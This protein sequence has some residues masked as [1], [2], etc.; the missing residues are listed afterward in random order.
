[1]GIKIITDS[2]SDLP[3]EIL[4]EYDI[5]VV[6]LEIRFDDKIFLDGIELMKNEFYNMMKKH[7]KL[8]KTAS[9]S[10][11]KFISEFD[12]TEDDILIITISSG[13]SST[14]N[15]A[16]I[17]KEIYEKNNK[18]KKIHVVDSLNASVGE[19]LIVL[20]AAQM[21]SDDINID[22]LADYLRK[23]AKEGHV[24]FLL[25]TLE[26]II[27]GGRIGKV[28][29]Q[30]ASLLS[31]KLIMKSDGNGIVD[32]AEKVRGSNRAFRRLI[33]I[34]GEKCTNHENRILAIAHAN[35]YAKAQEFKAI[36]EEKYKFKQ[37]I[38]STIGAAI[39]TYSGEGGILI[40]FI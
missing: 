35:C 25:D 26:N 22:E 40:S 39:G 23:C 14:Y 1:M 4:E 20:K 29:G 30:I 5:G 7:K 8:P 34:V 15:S 6:P 37:I 27:K 28:R 11:Q 21:A 17:A 19:G 12:K 36:I 31:I 3:Q 13:L 24:F 32:L 9:P 10:P 18:H 16:L 2:C 38:V 33:D